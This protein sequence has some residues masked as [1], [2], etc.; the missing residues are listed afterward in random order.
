MRMDRLQVNFNSLRLS[1]HHWIQSSILM[2]MPK[3]TPISKPI[4]I[5]EPF[6]EPNPIPNL[7]SGI[8]S[9]E[10]F[11][12]PITNHYSAVH[13]FNCISLFLYVL[14]RRGM[15]F[16]CKYRRYPVVHSL[17]PNR[18]WTDTLFHRLW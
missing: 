13:R 1:I 10:T 18:T 7:L 15:V 14:G 4:M 17:L 16:L 5:P 12:F 8:D 3:P 6:P 2:A 9:D 11:V